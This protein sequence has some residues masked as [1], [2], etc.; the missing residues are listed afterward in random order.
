MKRLT[1]VL[2]FLCAVSV[3]YSQEVRFGFTVSPV[4]SSAN[5]DAS[6]A[7]SV[8]GVS[9]SEDTDSKTGVA[10]GILLDYDING[11]DRYFLHSGLTL[12]HSGYEIVTTG[13]M[14]TTTAEVNADYIEIPLVLKLKTNDIG[15]LRY[16]GQFGLN[17]GFKVG[18]K[19]KEGAESEF[20]DLSSVNVGL[21]MGGGIEY[22]IS[23]ETTAVAG[24]YYNNGF[25]KIADNSAGSFKQNQLGLRLGIYF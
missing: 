8:D 5:V 20:T 17:N 7:A 3:T 13:R 6:N 1:L 2:L 19:I 24:V 18:D 14:G 15:Y 23:D 9:Y 4:F 10:Y 16:Y 11:E 12:H 21:N 25:S 22:N